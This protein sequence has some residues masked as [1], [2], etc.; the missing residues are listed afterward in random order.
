MREARDRARAGRADVDRRGVDGAQLH[1][2]DRSCRG[3]DF[4]RGDRGDEQHVELRGVQAGVLEGH[5]PG[6]RREI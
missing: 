3:S 1:C 6:G 4:V 2:H 5:P